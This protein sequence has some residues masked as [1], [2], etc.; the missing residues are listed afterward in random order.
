VGAAVVVAV[1]EAAAVAAVATEAFSF[2]SCQTP[3]RYDSSKLE[4]RSLRAPIKR[5]VFPQPSSFSSL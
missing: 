3:S 5:G 1:E 2:V 4:S